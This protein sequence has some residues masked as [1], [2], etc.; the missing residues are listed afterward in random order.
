M[1]KTK[2][3]LNC[4]LLA[5]IALLV[6]CRTAEVDVANTSTAMVD[7][8]LS[9]KWAQCNIGAAAPEEF[10]N[11]YAWGETDIKEKYN[12]DTYKHCNGTS[13]SLTK[14]CSYASFGHVDSKMQLER[15]DDVATATLGDGWRLPTIAEYEELMNKCTWVWTTQNGVNGYKVTGR[16]GKSIFLPAAGY[17]YNSMLYSENSYALYWL[18]SLN[19]AGCYYAQCAGFYENNYQHNF[20]MRFYG[21]TVRAVYDR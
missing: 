17:R 8:G 16:N 21:L 12:W 7:L 19:E 13:T 1:K 14:Y 4:L 15:H 3:S 2:L 9:V 10:G 5:I 18:N 20:K 11:Y 6:S